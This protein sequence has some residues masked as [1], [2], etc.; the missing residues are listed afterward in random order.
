MELLLSSISYTA[1]LFLGIIVNFLLW[2][3]F[4]LNFITS[5]YVEER[6]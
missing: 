4:N 2:L 6:T 5:M 1:L 3:I